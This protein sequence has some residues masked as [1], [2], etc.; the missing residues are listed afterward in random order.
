MKN[1]KTI[2]VVD[3]DPLITRMYQKR[4]TDDGYDVETASNGEEAILALRRKIPNLIILDIMMPKMNGVETLKF[5][6]GDAS[7]ASVSVII[8]SN[9]GD[10]TEDID[11]AKQMGALDYLVKSNITLKQLSERVEKVFGR[12]GE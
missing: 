3:D 5:L 2:L 8:L 11:K 9:L 10:R 7:T 1:K 6:K 4:L 12:A